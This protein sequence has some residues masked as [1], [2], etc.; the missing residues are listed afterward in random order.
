MKGKLRWALVLVCLALVGSFVS[1]ASRHDDG[2]SPSTHADVSRLPPQPSLD[3]RPAPANSPALD[4][5][6]SGVLRTLLVKSY[7]D[8]GAASLVPHIEKVEVHGRVVNLYVTPP[9][10]QVFRAEGPDDVTLVDLAA[11]LR[12][13]TG[14]EGR[15]KVS[16]WSEGVPVVEHISL[17]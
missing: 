12:Y 3:A 9:L 6:M 2:D 11:R 15:V 1:I 8:A 17:R 4:E 10:A 5:A 13:M 14:Y 7:R 16:V